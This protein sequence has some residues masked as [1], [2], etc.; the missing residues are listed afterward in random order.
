MGWDRYIGYCYFLTYCY[1][2]GISELKVSIM[3]PICNWECPPC[4]S[5]SWIQL[6]P[7]GNAAG[8]SPPDQP[9]CVFFI[10]KFIVAKLSSNMLVSLDHWII[11]FC[12]AFTTWPW[13]PPSALPVARQVQRQLVV[14]ITGDV[15]G[16]PRVAPARPSRRLEVWRVRC[17]SI[18]DK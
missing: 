3:F 13:H 1:L 15:F 2:V 10:R 5:Q 18:D 9:S 6:N 16:W 17:W 14:D 8:D 12:H 11:G 7:G 4:P